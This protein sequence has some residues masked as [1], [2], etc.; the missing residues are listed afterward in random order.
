MDIDIKYLKPKKSNY[1]LGE[2]VDLAVECKD[3]IENTG[4]TPKTSN[5]L[6]ALALNLATFKKLKE[7]KNER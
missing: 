1:N 4:W 2:L 6:L 7:F 3:I 5:Y